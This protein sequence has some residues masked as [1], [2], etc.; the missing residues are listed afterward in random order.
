LHN[1]LDNHLGAE[2]SAGTITTKQDA[3]DYLT[4]TFFFRRLHKNPTYYGLEISAEEHHD[5]PMTARQLAADYMIELVD[6]SLNDLAE[7]D[8]VLVHSNGDV[9]STP[10][11][12]IMSYYYLSHLTVR[13]MLLKARSTLSSTFGHVLAWVCLASEFDNLPVRHNEDLIN[14]ELAKNLPLGIAGLMDDLPMWDP[15][16]KAFLL[17]QAYMSRI[18][19]PISDYVGDCNSVLD[20]SIRII[21]AGVD[22]MAELG[23]GAVVKQMIQLLQCIK[24]ARWPHDY[25]LSILPAVGESLNDKVAAQAP[26]DLVALSEMPAAK[27]GLVCGIL[28]IPT[29][30]RSAFAK[31]A[32]NLP[33][34]SLRASDLHSDHFVVEILRRNEMNNA[35]GYIYAPKFPK[36]Q[37]EGYFVIAF[38]DGSVDEPVAIKRAGWSLQDGAGGKRGGRNAH[39]LEN[40]VRI[41][42]PALKEENK[43][44]VVVMSDSYPGMSWELKDVIVPAVQPKTIAIEEGSVKKGVEKGV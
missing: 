25:P 21:Q 18:E 40:R 33:H 32:G 34:I 23:R 5:N 7:S 41:R 1:V 24:S 6:K 4:W 39:K 30:Q 9:D 38:R 37:T 13:L 15:H 17:L 22:L 12:K 27:V 35:N 28:G 14:A 29:A 31:A 8:C 44:H 19:L 26:K 10:F 3:L 11:G 43:V 2:V 20:Q 42:V 36:P 16:V